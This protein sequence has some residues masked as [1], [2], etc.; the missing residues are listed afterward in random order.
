MSDQEILTQRTNIGRIIKKRQTHSISNWPKKFKWRHDYKMNLQNLEKTV[1]LLALDSK[2]KSDSNHYIYPENATFHAKL[3]YRGQSGVNLMANEAMMETGT[4]LMERFWGAFTS[5]A[6]KTLRATSTEP[7]K[8]FT[9][10]MLHIFVHTWNM[11]LQIK[12]MVFLFMPKIYQDLNY[13]FH[14]LNFMVQDFESRITNG[15]HVTKQKETTFNNFVEYL[16]KYEKSEGIFIKNNLTEIQA[17]TDEKN[18]SDVG[19]IIDILYN[20]NYVSLK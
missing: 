2:L 3:N 12:N 10:N 17:P 7:D 18:N 6:I 11:D 8:Y 16:S 19:A 9:I 13:P 5:Q 1:P 20:F 14:P 15:K 4:N